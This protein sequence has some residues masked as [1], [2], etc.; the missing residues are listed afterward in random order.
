MNRK[1]K[2]M[3]GF[4]KALAKYAAAVEEKKAIEAKH[5]ALKAELKAENLALGQR[6]QEM[7]EIIKWAQDNE[8]CDKEVIADLLRDLPQSTIPS[9]PAPSVVRKDKEAEIQ[10]TDEQQAAY[11]VVM[12]GRNIFLTGK[13]GTGKSHLTRYLIDQ[14]ERSKKNVIVC[15][16]TG[17]AARNIGGVT[18]HRTFGIPI[19]PLSTSEECENRQKLK[20]IDNADVIIIDEISMCR[21]DVFGFVARS[22]QSSM[23]RTDKQKQVIVIGD[24]LQLPP[25]LG[26]N[27]EKSYKKIYRD[28]IWPFETKEWRHMSFQ[29]IEL[30]EVIR[31]KDYNLTTALNNIRLGIPDFTI[32]KKRLFSE[33][34]PDA[35]TLC[36]RNID[37]S[38][39]NRKRLY[40]LKGESHTY[41][42]DSWGENDDVPVDQEIELKPSARI[43]LVAND[44]EGRWTNGT[45]ATVVGTLTDSIVVRFDDGSEHEVSPF[46]WET[47]ECHVYEGNNGKTYVDTDIIGC[48]TQ[49]PVK[50]A[51]A[52][53]IHRSQGQ[54]YEKVNIHPDGIFGEGMMYVGLSRCRS[55]DGMRIVGKLKEEDVK[56]NETV[57]KFYTTF[58]KRTPKVATK[59]GGKEI[60]KN[61]RSFRKSKGE[62]VRE[63]IIEMIRECPL[64]NLQDIATRLSIQRSA[65][66]KHVDRLKEEGRIVRIG[67]TKNGQW[68]VV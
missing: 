35:I 21:A 41:S 61:K 15:A 6:V 27:E 9:C 44:R 63:Q 25:V 32:L 66:Q 62:E 10:L 39:I 11:D 58:F 47:K 7:Q 54:T 67:A 33:D 43:I 46:T 55:L 64:Y 34:D 42:A 45:L 14:L 30:Q 4:R 50:L 19:K 18:L 60:V 36:S 5:K 16:P 26:S 40:E 49:L 1:D 52:I 65:V 59:K 29:C 38:A 12:S 51:Y 48:F 2:I 3:A 22:I 37:A 20:V 23:E 28:K 57:K 53:T 24:F 31:Q 56:V 13:A 17:I 68:R 8:L